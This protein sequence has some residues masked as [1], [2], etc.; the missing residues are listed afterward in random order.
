VNVVTHLLSCLRTLTCVDCSLV[1]EFLSSVFS[2]T[3]RIDRRL[4]SNT[5]ASSSRCSSRADFFEEACRFASTCIEKWSN[6]RQLN[7]LLE[8]HMGLLRE[9]ADDEHPL[10]SDERSS[11]SLFWRA[12]SVLGELALVVPSLPGGQVIPLLQD[13]FGELRDRHLVV[14]PS[15]AWLSAAQVSRLCQSVSLVSTVLHALR[16][17]TPLGVHVRR[18]IATLAADSLHPFLQHLCDVLRNTSTGK[19][20]QQQQYTASALASALELLFAL[21]RVAFPS[22]DASEET[23]SLRTLWKASSHTSDTPT[24][25]VRLFLL[26]LLLLSFE[27]AGARSPTKEQ[28]SILQKLFDWMQEEVGG[29]L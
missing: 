18:L 4:N 6:L 11:S 12:P 28:V 14:D 16:V 2:L 20:A 22:E 25:V 9:S 8:L 10:Q 24:C 1:E 15:Q 27:C 7:T 19:A 13:L 3:V 17:S 5:T 29:M 23:V 26:E 21:R